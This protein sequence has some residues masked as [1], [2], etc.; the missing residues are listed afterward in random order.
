MLNIVRYL[1][2]VTKARSLTSITAAPSANTQA[3]SL[4][5]PFGCRFLQPREVWISN[6]SE[7]DENVERIKTLH[8]KIFAAT[9]RVDIIHQNIDWQRKYRFVSFAHSKLRFECRGLL[10]DEK[11]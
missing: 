3:K 7:E 2:K 4:E 8:P 1:F 9:P 11:N 5:N 10:M 6:L